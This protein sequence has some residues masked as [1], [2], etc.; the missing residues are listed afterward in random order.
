MKTTHRATIVAGAALLAAAAAGCSSGSVTATT[1]SDTPP[2]THAASAQHAD[3][4]DTSTTTTQKPKPTH[5]TPSGPQTFKPGDSFRVTGMNNEKVADVTVE[6]FRRVQCDPEWSDGLA[7][8]V[9]MR[10]KVQ[11]AKTAGA[12]ADVLN[13]FEMETVQ[14]GTSKSVGDVDSMCSDNNADLVLKDSPMNM[15]PGSTYEYDIDLGPLK[16]TKAE[17]RYQPMGSSNFAVLTGTIK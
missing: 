3:Q 17:V 4:A 11:V 9:G 2:A 10:V 7:Q 8:T 6:G 13:P 12:D 16:G 15:I 5:S 14:N 1:P